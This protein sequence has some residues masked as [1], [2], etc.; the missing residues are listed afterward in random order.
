MTTATATKD[1]ELDTIKRIRAYLKASNIPLHRKDT[2]WF[3]YVD[4]RPVKANKP[5]GDHYQLRVELRKR[6]TAQGFAKAGWFV[7]TSISHVFTHPKATGHT[8]G[9]YGLLETAHESPTEA[10]LKR[11]RQT[12]RRVV[13]DWQRLA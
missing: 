11:M 13:E 1:S 7:H 10:E 2:N 4:K 8:I 5:N 12:V 3:I 9:G 6:K